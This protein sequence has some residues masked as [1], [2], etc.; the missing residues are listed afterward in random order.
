VSTTVNVNQTG[1]P[2]G[3]DRVHRCSAEDCEEW[4]YSWLALQFH[5]LRDHGPLAPIEG[6]EGKR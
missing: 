4:R 3:G 2:P 5:Q 1:R 6:S